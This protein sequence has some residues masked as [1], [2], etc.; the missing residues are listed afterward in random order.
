MPPYFDLSIS[1]MHKLIET[2]KLNF[3]KDI[4]EEAKSLIIV[5]IN[6]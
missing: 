3:I 1:K 2:G 4:S 6:I 5:N